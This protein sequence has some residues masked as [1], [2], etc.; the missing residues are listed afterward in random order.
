MRRYKIDDRYEEEIR[1]IEDS[2]SFGSEGFS[3][4]QRI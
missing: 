3:L 2:N 4:L 1:R